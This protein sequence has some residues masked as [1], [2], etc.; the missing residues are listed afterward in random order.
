MGRMRAGPRAAFAGLVLVAVLAVAAPHARPSARGGTVLVEYAGG[1]LSLPLPVGGE[2]EL[3]Y[4]NSVYRVEAIERFRS[5]PGEGF[6]LVEVASPS[7]AVL[8]EYYGA[9]MPRAVRPDPSGGWRHAPS[10]SRTHERLRV[11]ADRIGDRRLVVSGREVALRDLVPD[12]TVVVLSI[13][14]PRP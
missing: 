11:V 6:R 7:L 2:F 5:V 4:R 9:S 12:G 10:A 13:G 1:V 14:P 8:E 3:R